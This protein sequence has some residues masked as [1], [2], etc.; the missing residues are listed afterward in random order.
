MWENFFKHVDVL[1]ENVRRAVIS[2]RL[3]LLPKQNRSIKII[4]VAADWRVQ[5]HILDGNAGD[6]QSAS[7]QAEC[8]R[9]CSR[10]TLLADP[11]FSSL[12][13]SYEKCIE[14]Y[15]GIELFLAGIGHDGHIAFNE[16]GT[17]HEGGSESSA[18][19]CD[20][21]QHAG[22]SLTSRTREKTLNQE[23]IEANCRQAAL[24]CSKLGSH[25]CSPFS[26]QVFRQ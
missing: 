21:Q 22:S 24:N 23:T 4:R 11:T 3:N 2:T 7:L 12:H 15:G 13:C 6:G 9:Y 10:P 8:R 25:S 26:R 18:T 1:P 19:L 17:Q 16:P 5:V 14:S 20:A